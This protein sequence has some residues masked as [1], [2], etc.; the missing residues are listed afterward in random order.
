L[1]AAGKARAW[2]R[3]RQDPSLAAAHRTSEYCLAAARSAPLPDDAPRTPRKYGR[4]RARAERSSALA[5]VLESPIRR[6][7]IPRAAPTFREELP[8]STAACQRLPHTSCRPRTR[9]RKDSARAGSGCWRLRASASPFPCWQRRVSRS[10]CPRASSGSG[11]LWSPGS[12]K[13]R[14]LRPSRSR[15]TS[16]WWLRLKPRRKRETRFWLRRA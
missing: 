10:R 1:D 4:D 7:E 16:S 6:T 2:R 14:R 13:A 3:W 11:R 9:A 15:V 5:S 8:G 12:T